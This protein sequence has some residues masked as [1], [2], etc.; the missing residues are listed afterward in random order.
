MQHIKIEKPAVCTFDANI[1]ILVK[2]LENKQTHEG[3]SYCCISLVALGFESTLLSDQ[4]EK[5]PAHAR[6][7]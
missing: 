7:Y 1:L 5:F 3:N 4:S 2:E 6:G